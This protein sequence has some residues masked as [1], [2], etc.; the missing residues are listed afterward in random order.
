[1]KIYRK[2]LFFTE[3]ATE[4]VI[5]ITENIIFNEEKRRKPIFFTTK[6]NKKPAVFCFLGAIIGTDIPTKEVKYAPRSN[7]KVV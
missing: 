1:M 3:F 7:S 2:I 4:F 5:I 6:G